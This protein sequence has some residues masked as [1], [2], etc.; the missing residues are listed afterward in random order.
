MAEGHFREKMIPDGTPAPRPGES[1]TLD[2]NGLSR[3]R[4]N[5]AGS[6]G[7]IING[8]V[9]ELTLD[10]SPLALIIVALMDGRVFPHAN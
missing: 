8:L 7:P 9:T 1:G 2:E 4:R 3:Q 5:A 10:A 6:T